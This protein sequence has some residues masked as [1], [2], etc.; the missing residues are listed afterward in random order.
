MFEPKIFSV[1]K[2]NR[3][4]KNMLENDIILSG[5][6]VRGEISNYK[7]AASGHL[8]FTL[9]DSESAIGCVMFSG[10]ADIMP[11][12]LENGMTAV[13]CGYVSL[14]EKTGQHQLYAEAVIPEGEGS[15]NAAYRQLKERL[16]AEGLFDPDYRREITRRPQCIGVITSPV[17]AAV[18]DVI[19]V[20][21]RRNP[22]VKIIIYPSSV[23]GENA[24]SELVSALRLANE[25]KKA[26]TLILGRG[27]GSAE[28]LMAFNTEEVARAVFASEIPVI[29]AVGHET[30]FSITDFCADLRAPTPSAAAELAVNEL[31]ADAA[32]LY[33]CYSRLNTA[34]LSLIGREKDRLASL[35]NRP[36]LKRP[37]TGIINAGQRLEQ[38]EHRLLSSAVRGLEARR[39]AFE[40]ISARLNSA[41]PF[42]VMKRG[43][44]FVETSE[45]QIVTSTA[46]IEAGSG[47]K[48]T[49]ADG[50]FT[51]R[52]I[53]K[54]G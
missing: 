14:Y 2:V 15:L 51:A 32:L 47:I 42:T 17:G 23:Q 50:S 45:G 39:A 49:L 53:K 26:D 25:D 37:E 1:S 9:K 36:C 52:V 27:G 30:D 4:I 5:V 28:D 41:S 31:S 18:R 48:V 33:Q 16:E 38:L 19:N 40:L 24:P 3:Y 7:A 44:A 22:L 29:S 54:D 46:G 13:V 43:Y 21:R 11:F 10:D 34:V 35:I 6:W 12:E 20:A 8:Y